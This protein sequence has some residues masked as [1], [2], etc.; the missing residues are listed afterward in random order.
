MLKS[1]AIKAYLVS[2]VIQQ[3]VGSSF[4]IAEV[5]K[6][7]SSGFNQ[8]PAYRARI[9]HY[10][11]KDTTYGKKMQ[12]SC[13][14]FPNY[15][16][17][18]F[19]ESADRNRYANCLLKD[20]QFPYNNLWAYPI[21][22]GNQYLT[23]LDVQ[24]FQFTEIPDIVSCLRIDNSYLVTT[25]ACGASIPK[26]LIEVPKDLPKPPAT[27]T[28]IIIPKPTGSSVTSSSTTTTTTTTTKSS[29][30]LKPTSTTAPSCKTGYC[31]KKRGNGP[32][33]ACCSSSDDC[34]DTCNSNGKCGV[35]DET[36]EPKNAICPA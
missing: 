32:T 18:V 20:K 12:D 17:L 28:T 33:G 1:F 7:K 35:S 14:I 26:N 8:P 9:H 31:G 13:S 11:Q 27:T 22:V 5:D 25:Y 36:G 2:L 16:K 3:V 19:S 24:Y 34:L 29:S 4:F 10:E 23:G 6:A 15:D 21:G 30:S